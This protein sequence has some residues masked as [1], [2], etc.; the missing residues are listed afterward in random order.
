MT[1]KSALMA[2]ASAS[3]S[4]YGRLFFNLAD[5]EARGQIRAEIENQTENWET[6]CALATPSGVLLLGFDNAE[7][8]RRYSGRFLD[9]VAR[10]LGK[11][12][13]DTAMDL[14]IAFRFPCRAAS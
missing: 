13:I 5:V 7:N 8:R 12:W 4:A 14:R 3:R 6:F 10:E 2:L 9:D 1:N 11:D